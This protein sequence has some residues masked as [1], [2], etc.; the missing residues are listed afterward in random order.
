MAVSQCCKDG[1][2]D[3][4]LDKDAGRWTCPDCKTKWVTQDVQDAEIGRVTTWVRC[5]VDWV[6]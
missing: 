6:E 2:F 1:L 5:V 4:S 3:G